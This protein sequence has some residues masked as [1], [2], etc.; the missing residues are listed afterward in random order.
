MNSEPTEKH[1]ALKKGVL[2]RIKDERIAPRAR[3][4]FT[5]K[6]GLFWG[7]WV[8]TVLLGSVSVAVLI[9]AELNV[10]WETYEVTHENALTFFLETLPLIWLMLL[11]ILTYIGLFN[12]RHTKTGY[13]YS[14][15]TIIMVG[16]MGS[17]IGG[18]LLHDVGADEFLEEKAAVFVPLHQTASHMREVFWN[19]PNR[20]LYA[21]TVETFDPD[22][23][24][25]VL[26]TPKG[27]VK[28]FSIT[29]I[30]DESRVLI[31]PNSYVR[32]MATSSSET[33]ALIACHLMP[34]DS[35]HPMSMR[36]IFS[37]RGKLFEFI[38]Q[39][40]EQS[41]DADDTNPDAAEP[42][43]VFLREKIGSHPP[44]TILK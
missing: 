34:W 21:G 40:I 13:R 24:T 42:C 18:V 26:R 16:C 25:L 19:Q 2:T 31:E 33:D 38:E 41:N 12:L 36:G 3:V 14:L 4:Y 27:D 17:I 29:F 11:T 1:D 30:P 15:A 10:G 39:H 28:T 35:N 5:I 8:F 6:N 7:L 37:Q 43:K 32:I 44:K 9:F 22:S 20:G 23:D